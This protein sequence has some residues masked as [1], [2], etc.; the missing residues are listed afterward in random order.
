MQD[1]LEPAAIINQIAL[2]PRLYFLSYNTDLVHLC[3]KLQVFYTLRSSFL[4]GKD[5]NQSVL[6][7]GHHLNISHV[8]IAKSHKFPITVSTTHWSLNA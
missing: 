3:L 5:D 4:Q 8:D 1:N 7:C 2:A 6:E